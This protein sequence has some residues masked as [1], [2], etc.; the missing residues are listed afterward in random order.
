[1]IFLCSRQY[2]LPATAP[3]SV[4]IDVSRKTLLQ[5]CL[6]YCFI[7]VKESYFLAKF[8]STENIQ[9]HTPLTLLFGFG[10]RELG[11]RVFISSVFNEE[12]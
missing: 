1:M 9:A 10:P 2:S 12:P 7:P 5:N 4:Q 8:L 3:L 11:K 6:K